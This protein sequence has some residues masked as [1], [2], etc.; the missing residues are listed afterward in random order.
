MWLHNCATKVD[1]PIPG[2]PLNSNTDPDTTPPPHTR[3]NSVHPDKILSQTMSFSSVMTVGSSQ[4]SCKAPLAP[5]FW[6][7]PQ[8]RG[9]TCIHFS[10]TYCL[11]IRCIHTSIRYLVLSGMQKRHF[12]KNSMPKRYYP[13]W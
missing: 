2:S 11:L 4:Y 13:T 5:Q 6:H 9:W 1:F 3:S 7:Q 10:H 12:N 8:K